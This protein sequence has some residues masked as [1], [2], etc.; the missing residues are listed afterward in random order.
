[1]VVDFGSEVG[2]ETGEVARY[3]P[4]EDEGGGYNIAKGWFKRRES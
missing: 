3:P 2:E 1:M 4:G